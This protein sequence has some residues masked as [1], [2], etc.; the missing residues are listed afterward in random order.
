M[1]ELQGVGES[2]GVFGEHTGVLE[3][4]TG[5]FERYRELLSVFGGFWS[6]S[7]CRRAF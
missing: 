2:C 7:K 5:S 3:S 1:S 6:F 4:V